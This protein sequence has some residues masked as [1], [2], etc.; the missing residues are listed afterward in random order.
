MIVEISDTIFRET[1]SDILFQVMVFCGIWFIS[2][3]ILKMIVEIYES[4]KKRERKQKASV[5]YNRRKRE[6]EYHNKPEA[7]KKWKYMNNEICD[8]VEEGSFY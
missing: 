2:Y 5:I 6:F 1:I 3:M 8:I 4:N 7:W